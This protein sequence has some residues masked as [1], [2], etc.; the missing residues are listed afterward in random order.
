MNV[1]IDGKYL[2][3]AVARRPGGNIGNGTYLLELLRALSTAGEGDEYRVYL[4]GPPPLPSGAA[5]RFQAMPPSYANPFARLLWLL[6]RAIA[7]AP[8]DLFHGMYSL[9]MGISRIPMVLTVFEFSWMTHPEWYPRRALLNAWVTKRA[10]ARADR[11]ITGCHFMKGEIAEHFGV[12]EDRIHAIPLGVDPD[13]GRRRGDEEIREVQRRYAGGHPYLLA[14]G[15]IWPKKN[16]GRLLEAFERIHAKQPEL[17]LVLVGGALWDSGDVLRAAQRAAGAVLAG[18][19]PQ[20]DLVRLYQGAELFVFPSLY[21]GYGLPLHEA[22]AA[23]TPVAAAGNTS[24]AEV[25]GGAA[26]TFD[27]YDVGDMTATIAK[28]LGDASLRQ[29]LCERGAEV[30]RR[31]SWAETARQTLSVYRELGAR[32]ARGS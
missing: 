8:V 9:P 25:A 10:M 15:D 13:F 5:L 18:S 12:P 19:V 17:R 1:G 24:L 6:P 27:P 31:H 20:E 28:V 26:V 30:V 14:V 29:A 16:I 32:E 22:M 3:Q 2:S 7:R 21:E 4:S 11:V 23:G